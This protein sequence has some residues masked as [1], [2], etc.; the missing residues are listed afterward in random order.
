[1]ECKRLNPPRVD[2]QIFD[3]S[4]LLSENEKDEEDLKKPSK[5]DYSG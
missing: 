2:I 1:V 4:P 3:L 5:I